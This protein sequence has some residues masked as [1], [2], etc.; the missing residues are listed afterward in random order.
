MLESE[1]SILKN[2]EQKIVLWRLFEGKLKPKAGSLRISANTHIHTDQG[3][4]DGLD[5]NLSLQE[6]LSPNFLKKDHGSVEKEN[7][8]HFEV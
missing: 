2:E 8:G 6:N 3:L 5:K 7:L 1:S 4:L